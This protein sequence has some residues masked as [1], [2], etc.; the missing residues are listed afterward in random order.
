ME[1]EFLRTSNLGIEFFQ[2][3]KRCPIFIADEEKRRYTVLMSPKPFELRF[4]NIEELEAVKICAA[5]DESIFDPN[6]YTDSATDLD[7]RNYF[8]PGS[9][10][11]DSTYGS[12]QLRI[13]PTS[14][15]Y[16]DIDGRLVREG[17]FGKIIF[18]NFSADSDKS[19]FQGLKIY[20]AFSF[21][22]SVVYRKEIEE[23]ILD[24]SYDADSKP[25]DRENHLFI[26]K[27]FK[28]FVASSIELKKERKL[29]EDYIGRENKILNKKNVF[30]ETVIWEDFDDSISKTRKQDDYN[31]AILESDIVVCLIF[32]K[33]GNFTIEEFQMAYQNFKIKNKPVIFT[34][35]KDATINVTKVSSQEL[36]TR[37]SFWNHLIEIQ[38]FPTYFTSSKDLIIK[39][40]S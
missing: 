25:S 12:A 21:E 37:E 3:A 7:E 32:T 35:F 26:K 6:H 23:V 9:G 10:M 30:I 34:Y 4:P 18:R 8:L 16:L 15:N 20:L 19:F 1:S 24:F 27:T 33:A 31:R 36:Q 39:F 28:I 22:T 14:C 40:G 17:D 2:G 29:I 38:H 5:L 13:D 11:A